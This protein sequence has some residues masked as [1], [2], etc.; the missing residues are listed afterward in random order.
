MFIVLSKVPLV[1]ALAMI[2][3][4]DSQI[5]SLPTYGPSVTAMSLLKKSAVEVFQT[6]VQGKMIA[7]LQELYHVLKREKGNS[8]SEL[9]SQ[10]ILC[11]PG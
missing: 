3:T 10:E 5:V 8:A 7:P 6:C 9:T 4:V 1:F 2:C 11:F